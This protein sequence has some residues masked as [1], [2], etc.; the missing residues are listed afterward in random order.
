[1]ANE[2]GESGPKRVVSW[3]R[4]G[5][6]D[7]VKRCWPD[8]GAQRQE[9]TVSA[10]GPKRRGCKPK[11]KDPLAVENE[12]LRRENRQLS[13]RH[14]SIASVAR[15]AARNPWHGMEDLLLYEKDSHGRKLFRRTR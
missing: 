15:Y 14:R 12:R 10:L 2:A 6:P 5:P 8:V 1:M 4:I 13:E 3:A 11:R 7:R 9:S